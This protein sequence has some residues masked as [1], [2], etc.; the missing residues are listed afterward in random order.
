MASTGS[1]IGIGIGIAGAVIGVGVAILA[2]LSPETLF[3]MTGMSSEVSG[4]FEATGGQVGTWKLE[5]DRC[6]SGERDGF[7]GVWLSKK[8]DSEHW[9]K[10]AKDPTTGKNVVTV[11]IPNTQKARVFRKCKVLSASVR[12]TNTRVNRIWVVK[13]NVEI[14]CPDEGFK[15]K[16][17]FDNCY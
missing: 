12:R 1:K 14:D 16:V 5:P 11:K 10:V 3:S 7:F 17:T 6:K 15:G 13:G 9:V 2:S 8:G 4:S